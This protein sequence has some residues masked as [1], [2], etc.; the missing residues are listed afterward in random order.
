MCSQSSPPKIGARRHRSSKVLPAEGSVAL[1]YSGSTKSGSSLRRSCPV[2]ATKSTQARSL[3]LSPAQKRPQ[4]S[5]DCMRNSANS[6]LPCGWSATRSHPGNQRPVSV[7]GM[8]ITLPASRPV[9]SGADA[10]SLG[11]AAESPPVSGDVPAKR[12]RPLSNG[13]LLAERCRVTL[14]ES[15]NEP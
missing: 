12:E 1:E 15:E 14:P 2:A 9:D 4:N 13:I 6:I 3:V 11:F 10:Q 7:L 8:R 5:R